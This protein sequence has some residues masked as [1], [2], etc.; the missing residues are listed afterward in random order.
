MMKFLIPNRTDTTVGLLVIML[1]ASMVLPVLYE[2]FG[3][4]GRDANDLLQWQSTLF[5]I[6]MVIAAATMS[7]GWRAGKPRLM[8]LF[9]VTALICFPTWLWVRNHCGRGVLYQHAAENSAA[10]ATLDFDWAAWLLGVLVFAVWG[11]ICWGAP[12]MMLL[13]RNRWKRSDQNSQQPKI[14][15]AKLLIG[16]A[17]VCFAMHTFQRI[18]TING[19]GSTAEGFLGR[20]GSIVANTLLAI[21]GFGCFLLLPSWILVRGKSVWIT[22]ALFVLTA[23]VIAGAIVVC[24]VN[25]K[26]ALLPFFAYPIFLL[27]AARM[28]L[29]PTCDE[30]VQAESVAKNFNRRSHIPSIWVSVPILLFVG[31]AVLMS[32][33]DLQSLIAGG[34]SSLDWQR[35]R[36]I[37]RVRVLSEGDIVYCADQNWEMFE[38]QLDENSPA[39]IFQHALPPTLLGVS[40]NNMDPRFDTANVA[41]YPSHIQ[42]SGGRITSDQLQELSKNVGWLNVSD[43]EVVDPRGELMLPPSA[44][45]NWSLSSDPTSASLFKALSQ[46]NKGVKLYLYLPTKRYQPFSW[47]LL[48]AINQWA[49]S[50]NLSSLNFEALEHIPDSWQPQHSLKNVILQNK[51]TERI[52]HEEFKKIVRLDLSV[53][54]MSRDEPILWDAIFAKPFQF[55]PDIDKE[56]DFSKRFNT[57]GF[58]AVAELN[59]WVYGRNERQKISRLYM[60]GCE[61]T[62]IPATDVELEE[63]SYEAGW[64]TKACPSLWMATPMLPTFVSRQ[65]SVPLNHLTDHPE[66]KALYLGNATPV[67][68]LRFLA[69][70]PELEFL[71]IRLDERLDPSSSGF[72][73]ATKLK[74]LVHYGTPNK[75]TITE[76]RQQKTL[77]K[78]VVVR[79]DDGLLEQ[80]LEQANLKKSI[81][82]VEVII[83]PLNSPYEIPLDF[84]EHAE[85]VGKEVRER[86]AR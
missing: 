59:H 80:P 5:V 20:G 79:D 63:L 49:N 18:F 46:K 70:L 73:T 54:L 32:L 19:W 10:M 16:I 4:L 35:A 41:G 68:D 2:A 22:V 6:A 78:F 8:W 67:D 44:I 37:R 61:T 58:E 42:F 53:L 33:F 30:L 31:C 28:G 15:R 65:D 77:K 86:L 27:V 24:M 82:G 36:D 48:D 75:R 26:P 3:I 72:E 47:E 62:A 74:T 1:I 40:I 45:V 43:L 12:T 56:F 51:Q 21:F 64:L 76:L 38:Y 85:R 11:L 50:D 60:P 13:L 83:L 25:F 84:Q 14:S 7:Q 39:D 71:A 23:L 66:L 55:Y 29:S 52:T 69:G 57:L 9:V 34:F 17:I 81:P